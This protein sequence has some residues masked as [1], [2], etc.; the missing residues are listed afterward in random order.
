MSI[1]V[2]PQLPGAPLGTAARPSRVARSTYMEQLSFG[3]L[4]RR[5]RKACGLTQDQLGE[6]A[7]TDGAYISTLEGDPEKIPG[8]DMA[9][10][11][12]KALEVEDHTSFV[13]AMRYQVKVG[14]CPPWQV[15]LFDDD[16]LTDPEKDAI[17]TLA[18]KARAAPSR[19]RDTAV[20]G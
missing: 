16:D 9:Q 10:R 8:H 17:L 3:E 1:A 5:H 15:A 18:G 2:A 4:V 7:D 13:R 12:L 14:S 20:S 6:K 11:L 19:D